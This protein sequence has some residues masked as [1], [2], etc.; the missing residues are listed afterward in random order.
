MKRF[1]VILLLV[2]FAVPS[3][4]QR[5][6][7][8]DWDA[9]KTQHPYPQWFSDAKLGIFIHWG[10]YSVPSFSHPE[11]YAEWFYRGLMLEDSNRVN[12]MKKNYGEN[13][14]YRDFVPLF[15]GE[16]F[17]AD[18]W[19]DLFQRAG[20]KYIIL[21]TKHHDG[22]C[23]WDS[24]YAPEWNSVVSGPHRDIVGEVSKAVREKGIRL[25]FYYSLPEWTNPRHIWTV[26]PNDSIADYVDNHMIPQ[27]KELLTKYRPT[28]LFTDGEWDNTA[29]Q[30]HAK[31]LISWYYNLM[32]SEAI[33]NDRWGHGAD[34]GFKTPEYKGAIMD[35]T[36]PWA[37]CRGIGRSFGFNRN[38]PL[39][40][41]LSS[42]ELIRH[43]VKL[44]AAGGG[45]T[46]NVGPAADGKI[47]MLQQERLVDLGQ[48]LKVNGEAIY[49][50]RPYG[51][52]YEY[53]VE[54]IYEND[55]VRTVKEPIVCYTR[56]GSTVYAIALDFPDDQLVLN[57]PVPKK[58]TRVSLLGCDRALPWKYKNG[59][60]IIDTRS[61]RPGDLPCR[62]AWSF[63]I[64]GNKD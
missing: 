39:E 9:I 18:E 59:Q 28:L 52:I 51:Q 11:G 43:F 64:S 29:E 47:P 21:V 14:Q 7:P 27:F 46:L 42:D 31:E 60:L 20:A 19:A 61:I 3:F 54:T 2:C 24:K 57:I 25:G 13:F 33:V 17:D 49:G 22:Y 6:I 1:F 48:W 36:R 12:F 45:M 53:R 5:Q 16:L 23:L 8:A 4:A 63:K 26:D 15:K 55:S 10:L 37:E 32:G 50:S 58:G 35:T 34:Y 41:Y 30:W 56:Q 38:E 44:V 62:A 40:N